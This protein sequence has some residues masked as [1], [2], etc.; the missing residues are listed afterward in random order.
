MS[1][2]INILERPVLDES[3]IK[4]EYHSYS[5]YLQTFN[6]SDEIRIPIQNQDLLILPCESYIY[7]EGFIKTADQSLAKNAKF[8]N[9]CMAYAFDEIRY[10]LNGLEIDRTRNLGI[11]TTIKNFVSLNVNESKALVSA[12]WSPTEDLDASKS[13]F[14]FTVPLKL[15]LGFAEDFNKI[16]VNSKH[17]L[18]LIRS[19]NDANVMFSTNV[20]EVPTLKITNVLWKVPH[21]QLSDLRKLELFNIIKSSRPL[22]IAFRSWDSH[23]NPTLVNGTNHLWNVKLSLQNEKPRFILIG[24]QDST[25]A[26]KNTFINCDLTN[27]KVYLN[28]ESYPY[29]DL[30]LN[31]SREKY[32]VLYN[33]Y[34]KFQQ[35]YYYK[36]PQPLLSC[37]EFK[38]KAPLMV[39]DVTHQN[40][41]V[42]S[43]PVDIRIEFTTLTNTPASTQAYCLLLHER[44]I[45]YTPIT[46]MIRKVI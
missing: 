9:N 25:S 12:G 45:E 8:K 15:L 44:V 24:F 13:Y 4:N 35:S 14:N 31:F 27:I 37:A 46:N 6:N 42:K 40:E 22:Q 3:I 41:I 17:E 11:S 1:G 33:L 16:I 29:E 20:D 18:I 10:E 26:L 30:G 32:A 28:S 21:I 5:S 34:C 23:I 38:E 39:I 43:G 2:I 36:D 19:K 7:I